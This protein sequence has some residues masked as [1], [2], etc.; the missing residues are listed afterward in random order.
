MTDREATE[1]LARR[2]VGS[3]PEVRTEWGYQWRRNDGTTFVRPC[4]NEDDAREWAGRHPTRAVVLRREIR[5]GPW[6]VPTR[7]ATR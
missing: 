4:L 5:T 6:T 7:E 3:Q 2:V 1:E